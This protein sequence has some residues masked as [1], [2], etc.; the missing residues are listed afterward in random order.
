[1]D[2]SAIAVYLNRKLTDVILFHGFEASRILFQTVSILALYDG[3]RTKEEYEMLKTRLTGKVIHE[4]DEEELH[5]VLTLADESFIADLDHLCLYRAFNQMDEKELILIHEPP[6]PYT[7]AQLAGYFGLMHI[8]ENM[9]SSS[10]KERVCAVRMHRLAEN[11]EI[12]L[13]HYRISLKRE[14]LPAVRNA[15]FS[16]GICLRPLT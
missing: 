8:P 5:E 2:I 9:Y 7:A 15:I 3:C 14:N 10:Y 13:R 1:M 11:L 12:I 16:G 6:Q 4:T